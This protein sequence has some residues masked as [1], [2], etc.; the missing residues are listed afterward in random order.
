MVKAELWKSSFWHDGRLKSR[1]E[2]PQVRRAQESGLL[3]FPVQR[4]TMMQSGPITRH[5]HAR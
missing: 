2:T 3:P 5:A 4:H 1:S